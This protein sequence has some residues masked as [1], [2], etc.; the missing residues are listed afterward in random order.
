[1][2]RKSNSLHSISLSYGRPSS[3]YSQE[4]RFDTVNRLT[5]TLLFIHELFS[6]KGLYTNSKSFLSESKNRQTNWL[7]LYPKL[8]ILNPLKFSVLSMIQSLLFF[9]FID[10]NNRSRR[11]HYLIDTS[12]LKICFNWTQTLTQDPSLFSICIPLGSLLGVSRMCQPCRSR[13]DLLGPTP[14]PTSF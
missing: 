14:P 12:Y 10:K 5:F 13:P 9:E 6:V 11:W 1:M 8:F 3:G 4:G 7:V 2:S